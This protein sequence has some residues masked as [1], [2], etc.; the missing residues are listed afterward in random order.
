MALETTLRVGLVQQQW[1]PDPIEHKAK[2]EEGIKY[3]AEQ[4]AKLV[5]LQ[6][7]TLSPYFCSRADVS[8]KAYIEDIGTGPSSQFAKEVAQKYQVYIVLSLVERGEQGNCYNTAVTFA[9]NGSMV[10]KTRK[11]HIPSG[12]G[13][14]ETLSFT[15]GIATYPIHEIAGHKMATPTCYD[16][17][18]PELARI[19]GLKG[20][21][22]LIYP[23]AIGGEPTEPGFDSQR[24]W[25]AIQVAHAIANNC[26]VI[27][28]NRIG[29]ESMGKDEKGQE[30][31]LT[32]YGS[33][34]IAA[35]NGK[36]LAQ[37]PRD[38]PAVLVASLDFNLRDTCKRLFPFAQQ[39]R[40][41]DYTPL[42]VGENPA[43][44][45]NIYKEE[46]K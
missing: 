11:Q 20:A 4:G 25:Q 15:P 17:W 41:Q 3:A 31:G 12:E 35:P 37:A 14:N 38:Q 23:T 44:L 10:G 5:C 18:F 26:F 16:Q 19:Y 2:L 36:I 28:A 21:E 39:R 1:Y 43:L 8:A 22:V 29:T 6:E 9:P 13:Y 45:P 27:A 34:F 24:M 46:A 40:P 33:S 30:K 42:V 7:L 32:L